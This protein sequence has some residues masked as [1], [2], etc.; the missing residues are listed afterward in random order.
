MN[1]SNPAKVGVAFAAGVVMALAGAMIYVKSSSTHTSEATA[2]PVVQQIRQPESLNGS[3]ADGAAKL[4]G[5]A[6]VEAPAPV[7]PP[8]AAPIVPQ[9]AIETPAPVRHVAPTPA[10]RS[11]YPRRRPLPESQSTIRVEVSQMKSPAQLPDQLPTPAM[12]PVRTVNDAPPPVPAPVNPPVPSYSAPAPP[13]QPHSVTLASGTN[14]IIRLGETLSTEHNYS[15][16]TFRASLDRP[17]VVD[18]FIIAEKGSKVLG[19]IVAADKAGKLEGTANLQLALTEINT[20]DGQRVAVQTTAVVR[21]G[22]SNTKQ[23]AAKIGGGA[24]LG[25]IIGA[26]AGG[27]KGAAIGAGA[28]GAAGT[29]A[30]LLG[31][32]K[33]AVISNETQLTFQLATSTTITEHIN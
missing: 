24:V 25:A 32:T 31:K 21:K 26:L 4:P 29:G 13:P 30:V 9:A 6:I 23:E 3:K 12:P 19:K 18:G 22:P 1:P 5:P 27:G 17:I 28:G 16:D 7:T 2:A 20:T 15:G 14:V 8:P 11:S 33:P 10:S